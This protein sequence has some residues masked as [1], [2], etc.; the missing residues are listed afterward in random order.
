[1]RIDEID[2]K[3]T[4]GWRT[5]SENRNRRDSVTAGGS[6]EFRLGDGK[7]LRFP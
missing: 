3:H 4:G 7:M 1:M 2:N 5:Y 6:D